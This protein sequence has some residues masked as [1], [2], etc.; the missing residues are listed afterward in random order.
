MFVKVSVKKH[1]PIAA[2]HA[3]RRNVEEDAGCFSFQLK[4]FKA[5]T[6]KHRRL[7]R[8]TAL[9]ARPGVGHLNHRFQVPV[10]IPGGVKSRRLG[11]YF[12]VI[13]KSRQDRLIPLAIDLRLQIIEVHD[14][15]PHA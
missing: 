15:T 4:D 9:M 12:D 5:H 14:M 8:L 6:G 2:L 1:R 11:R 10:R 3:G 7:P 13:D